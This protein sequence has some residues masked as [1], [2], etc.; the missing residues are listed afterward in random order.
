MPSLGFKLLL[1]ERQ[2]WR[3]RPG[4]KGGKVNLE[5][6]R[7]VRDERCGVRAKGDGE[8]FEEQRV[9]GGMGGKG[10]TSS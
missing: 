4:R 2:R 8:V 9:K 1:T 3:Q 5:R 6:R 7:R 10:S